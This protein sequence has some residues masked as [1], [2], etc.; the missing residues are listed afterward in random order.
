MSFGRMD[1]PLERVRFLDDLSV[2]LSLDSGRSGK[3]ADQ[4][5]SIDLDVPSP[6]IFR[7]SYTD[8]LL[9]TDVV[10]KAIA[11]ATK[12]LQP[13]E[14]PA[15]VTDAAS[16]TVTGRP[17]SVTTGASTKDTHVA[18][19]TAGRRRSSV[20]RRRSSVS[21]RRPSNAKTTVIV[22]KQ[23]VSECAFVL[24]WLTFKAQCAYRWIPIRSCCSSTRDARS[25]H[26]V[27]RV[28]APS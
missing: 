6:V 11:V 28:Q 12:S 24:M 22:S 18:I 16:T 7:A 14:T 15:E 21:R 13:A 17:T 5:T 27:G 26:N 23:E 9:I 3:A 8:I 25:T 10:N 19:A 1:K 4:K 2:A 20:S